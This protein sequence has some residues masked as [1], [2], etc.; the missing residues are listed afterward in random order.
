[1][2]CAFSQV[3]PEVIRTTDYNW[4]FAY[5]GSD[6]ETCRVTVRKEDLTLA[7]MAMSVV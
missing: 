4:A 1:M 5:T 3:I 2:F 6:G 7:K